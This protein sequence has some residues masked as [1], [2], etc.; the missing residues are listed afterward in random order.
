MWLEE[1]QWDCVSCRRS[2]CQLT[3]WAQDS[4]LCFAESLWLSCRAKPTT[5]EQGVCR[6]HRR[7]NILRLP[8]WLIIKICLLINFSLWH[9][10]YAVLLIPP[11][12]CLG[13]SGGRPLI[14][15]GAAPEACIHVSQ[16]AQT[17]CDLYKQVWGTENG[18]GSQDDDRQYDAG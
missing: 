15:S 3:L 7:W 9:F 16:T 5:S 4:G 6:A 10:I 17:Y 8:S 11:P 2:L 12:S 13:D 14:K 1:A 18:P